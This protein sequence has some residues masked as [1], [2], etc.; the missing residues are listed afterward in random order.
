MPICWQSETLGIDVNIAVLSCFIIKGG[1]LPSGRFHLL[2]AGFCGLDV[3]L[4][5]C[6]WRFALLRLL[7]L[8]LLHEQPTH[9]L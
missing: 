6:C 5:L 3:G 7:Q 2:G 1:V 8:K 9:P 4:V